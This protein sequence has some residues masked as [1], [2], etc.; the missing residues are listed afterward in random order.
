MSQAADELREILARATLRMAWRLVSARVATAVALPVWLVAAWALEPWTPWVVALGLQLGAGLVWAWLRRPT[1]ADAARFIDD[2]LGL[3]GR[4]VTSR[5]RLTA[6]DPMSIL[7]LEDTRS[8]LGGIR[9]P[10]PGPWPWARLGA[11]LLVLAAGGVGRQWRSSGAPVY[12]A[13]PQHT[14]PPGR[15][16]APGGQKGQ[17]QGQGAHD[18]SGP[19][20]RSSG[21][22]GGGAHR[23]GDAAEP[24]N[25]HPEAQAT[26][27]RREVPEAK[28]GSSWRASGTP[29]HGGQGSRGNE[30]AGSGQSPRGA[31]TKAS[32][33]G[34]GEA[35]GAL[36][37]DRAGGAPAEGDDYYGTG[38]PTSAIL[39][40][41]SGS[42]GAA[43]RLPLRYAPVV[44]RYQASNQN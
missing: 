21:H 8:R 2:E 24:G 18:A 33:G 32:A 19:R 9:I 30:G 43:Y 39:V 35:G 20:R 5:E 16:R 17:G 26:G 31:G 6:Q 23:P 40:P 1:A 3:E 28:A 4:L 25:G 38:I 27:P 37:M 11:A 15:V 10:R 41:T 12:L 44:E 42:M 7:L 22:D 13:G 34:K 36:V 29:G 14:E